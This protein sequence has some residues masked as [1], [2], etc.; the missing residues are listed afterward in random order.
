MIRVLAGGYHKEDYEFLRDFL[1]INIAD[2][3]S[4][5]TKREKLCVQ[6]EHRRACL[7]VIEVMEFLSREA[8]R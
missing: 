3:L 8:A 4:D 5:C 1:E 7:D 6:C 2:V